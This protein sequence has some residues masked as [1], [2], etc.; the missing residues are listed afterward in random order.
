MISAK[1]L[2]QVHT[3]SLGTWPCKISV[4]LWIFPLI[5]ETYLFAYLTMERAVAVCAPMF[6]KRYM[7]ERLSVVLPSIGIGAILAV[8]TVLCLTLDDLDFLS[9]GQNL[10]VI[11]NENSV[12]RLSIVF[13]L[14]QTT[15]I[16]FNCATSKN[17]VPHFCLH[18]DA[19]EQAYTFYTWYACVTY[20]IAH[21]AIMLVCS[22]LISAS[23]LA[24]KRSRGAL[25]VSSSADERTSSKELQASVTVVTL[26]L[27]QC[28][29]YVPCAV[30]CMLYCWAN[31]T[32]EVCKTILVN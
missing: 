1:P 7:T 6:A 8:H 12:W 3:R 30:G 5:A 4:L 18:S 19:R 28:L 16:N 31:A 15:T 24:A 29:V 22:V 25:S 2:S 20:F 26:A 27:L 23:L 11:T 13:I 17:Y 9:N 21:P 14:L 32:P 10:C